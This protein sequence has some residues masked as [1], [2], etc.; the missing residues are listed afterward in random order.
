MSQSRRVARYDR[1]EHQWLRVLRWYRRTL[2][3]TGRHGGRASPDAEDFSDALCQSV[4]HL[5]DWLKNDPRQTTIRPNEIE[6][7]ANS[8]PALIVVADLANGTKHVELSAKGS[9]TNDVRMGLVH[10]SGQDDPNDPDGIQRVWVLVDEPEREE[11]REVVDV[12]WEG[13]ESWRRWLTDSGL[14]VPP[15]PQSTPLGT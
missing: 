9:R 14:D 3:A 11:A 6:E 5:K 13:I 15:D 7:F 8:D 12:A 1:W 10:W 4:W 2:D